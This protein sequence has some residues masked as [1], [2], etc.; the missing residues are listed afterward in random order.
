MSKTFKDNYFNEEDKWTKKKSIKSHKQ[1]RIKVN[2]Y[3][4]LIEHGEDFDDDELE[5]I[6]EED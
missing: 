5:E 1:K 4:R 2:E 6:F 3:L